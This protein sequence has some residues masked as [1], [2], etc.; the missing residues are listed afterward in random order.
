MSDRRRFKQSLS[1]YKK[2]NQVSTRIAERITEW[3]NEGK[4]CLV[5]LETH[6]FMDE[7]N[8]CDRC[9]AAIDLD[10]EGR[11]LALYR[12]VGRVTGRDG[13]KLRFDP[14]VLV[15]CFDCA[16]VEDGEQLLTA[17]HALAAWGRWPR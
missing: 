14:W 8:T 17:D 4:S 6:P 13:D 15:E 5:T 10:A 12:A 9:G 16:A 2:E 1:D 3:M 7:E 11:P